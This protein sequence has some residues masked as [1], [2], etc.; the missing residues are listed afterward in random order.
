MS[1]PASDNRRI[2][3]VDDNATIHEDFRRILI[4]DHTSDSLDDE[5]N[6][7]F[8]LA[9]ARVESSAPFEI[10]SALQGE[11]GLALTQAARAA[12]RPFALAFVD[13]RMPPG[14]DGLTTIR[15]LWDVD[16]ELQVVICTAYSDNSWEEIRATLPER[17]R[18]LVLKKP[19]DK[20]EALQL[21]NALTEKWNLTET[22]RRQVAQL[23]ETVAR[24]TRELLTAKEAA[25]AASRAKSEFLAT[26]SHELRTPMN[27]VMGM[28][29]LL[30]DSALSESQRSYAEVVQESAGALLALLDGIMDYAKLE[31]GQLRRESVPFDLRQAA[32]ETIRLFR[33]SAE[34]KGLELT[35]AYPP[36]VPRD[37]L[38]DPLRLRQILVNLVGNAVKFTARGVV[39]VSVVAEG[40]T[41]AETALSLSVRDTGVGIPPEKQAQ[42]FEKFTQADS[43][44]SRRYGGAGLGL[45]LCRRL[46]EL[47]GGDVSFV[48]EPGVG[49]TFTFRLK[50]EQVAVAAA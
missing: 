12:G 25:E 42:I 7:L 49:S 34:E 10:Q 6:R 41:G 27:G 17:E 11:E 44:S 16:P 24:R 28:N 14:W 5:A 45:A 50:L 46:G 31:A 29:R 43:S 2:L 23:E 39:A 3:L 20:I 30:L 9:P 47:L 48:S 35:L 4:A 33:A 18:W 32:E 38:G 37:F 13:M 40:G 19:F 1:L 36:G 22:I 8:G 26:M 21:A 15:K